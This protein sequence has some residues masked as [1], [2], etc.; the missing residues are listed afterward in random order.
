MAA[1]ERGSKARFR[2]QEG[3]PRGSCDWL[4]RN[5][6]KRR[7]CMASRKACLQRTPKDVLAWSQC[8]D[9]RAGC[10]ADQ[11]LHPLI[12]WGSRHETGSESLLSAK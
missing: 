9:L 4:P 11:V 10:S 12:E 8:R 7:V 5:A 3:G 6:M 1:L 2:R